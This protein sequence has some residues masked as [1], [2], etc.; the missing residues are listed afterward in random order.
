MRNWDEVSL[1]AGI[2][3][4]FKYGLLDSGELD[5]KSIDFRNVIIY[6][7][8]GSGFSDHYSILSFIKQ[9][10]EKY[11]ATHYI[12]GAKTI[13]LIEEGHVRNMP[14]EPITAVFAG[15]LFQNPRGKLTAVQ[16]SFAS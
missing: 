7:E 1:R 15:M 9:A 14:D 16:Y 11:G 10:Y 6:P 12:A 3:E 4:P 2:D 5:R 13:R 8:S